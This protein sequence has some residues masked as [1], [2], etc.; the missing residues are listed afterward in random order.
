MP[1][2]QVSDIPLLLTSVLS[3]LSTPSL[4]SP[5]LFARFEL[6]IHRVFQHLADLFF[7]A[8]LRAFLA[9][10][11]FE[12]QVVQAK[13]ASDKTLRN[14]GKRTVVIRL[15][16]GHPFTLL[17]TV[18]SW[19]SAPKRG[20]RGPK[21]RRRRGDAGHQFTPVLQVLGVR[22]HLSSATWSQV[23]M[24]AT[25]CESL[26]AARRM[27]LS[28]GLKLSPKTIHRHCERLGAQALRARDTW[29]NSSAPAEKSAAGRRVVLLMDGGRCRERQPKAGRKKKNGYRDFE[30][31][32]V[33]P[34]QLVIYTLDEHGEL[35][36]K[37]GKVADAQISE[38]PDFIEFFKAYATKYE[39]HKAKEVIVLADGQPWQWERLMERLEEMGVKSSQVTQILDKSHAVQRLYE[40][41]NVPKW[42][43][44]GLYA[45]FIYHGRKLLRTGQVLALH[46][47]C[48]KLATGRRAKKIKSLAGYFLTHASRMKYDEYALAKQPC[49]SG[50]VE[51]MIRQVINM[52][53]KAC[54]KFW[55][56]ENAQAMLCMRSWLKS[57]RFGELIGLMRREPLDWLEP[58]HVQHSC[59]LAA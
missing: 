25:A 26:E 53:L 28:Q 32:W 43:T 16:G 31:P 36:R 4:E 20:A 59:A 40:I 42:K 18:V 48:M 7:S 34:R 50:M 23:A 57:E 49:G 44:S 51:S 39:V 1:P 46:A 52:R 54:G 33:E 35:D 29:L 30:A 58:A 5:E 37:W 27:L 24:A 21:R 3:R 22:E 45:R 17:T 11:D 10:S 15:L 19:D 14:K 2:L 8:F 55:K 41:A 56:K 38:A 12:R 6:L 13:L 47:H 9:H